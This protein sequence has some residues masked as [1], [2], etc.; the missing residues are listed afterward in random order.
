MRFCYCK[1]LSQ[2]HSEGVIITE[3]EYGSYFLAGKNIR[4]MGFI[5][6]LALEPNRSWFLKPMILQTRE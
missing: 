6:H 2:K 5:D 3:L 1:T 4:N